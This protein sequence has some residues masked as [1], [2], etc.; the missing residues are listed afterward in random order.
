MVHSQR[1]APHPMS[2]SLPNLGLDMSSSLHGHMNMSGA[3]GSMGRSTSLTQKPFKLPKRI[4]GATKKVSYSLHRT[5]KF[6]K[7]PW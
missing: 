5:E 1:A 2:M 4:T 7:N 6:H 3:E